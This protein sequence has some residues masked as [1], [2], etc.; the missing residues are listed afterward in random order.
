M[1]RYLLYVIAVGVL[2]IAAVLVYDTWMRHQ[3]A[4]EAED[5]LTEAAKNRPERFKTQEPTEGIGS[6][7][8]SPQIIISI[9]ELGTLRVSAYGGDPETVENRDQLRA[10]LEHLIEELSTRNAGRAVIVRASPS[11][12]YDEVKKVIDAAK[13]AG[14][15][16]VRLQTEDQK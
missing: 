14:A 16:P 7:T 9:D 15:D 1:K 11:L 10:R 12:K 8:S 3:A 2:I 4:K 6:L 13:S 5:A